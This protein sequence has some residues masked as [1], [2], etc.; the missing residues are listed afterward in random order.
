LTDEARSP[1]SK[2]KSPRR[3]L[4][5]RAEIKDLCLK[6]HTPVQIAKITG[7][8]KQAVFVHLKNLVNDGELRQ[9]QTNYTKA[10]PA[11]ERK[12]YKIIERAIKEHKFFDE[13]GLFPSGRKMIYH[14]LELAVS[15]KKEGATDDELESQGLPVVPTTDVHSKEFKDFKRRFTEGYHGHSADARRGIRARNLT[16]VIGESDIDVEPQQGGLCL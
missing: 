7:R 13:E 8:T 4:E 6:G 14:L 1:K 9:D 5:F 3:A 2:R 11:E 12:W 16:P 10:G 15:A